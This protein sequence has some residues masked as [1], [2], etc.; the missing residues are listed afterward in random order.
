MLIMMAGLEG[1]GKSTLALQLAAALPG[2]VLN[3]DT[4]RAALFSPPLVEY[5]TAQ[6]DFCVDIM[7]QVAGYLLRKAPATYVILDGRPF[8][9]R[10]Q[11]DA[12]VEFAAK[13]PDTLKIIHCT[14][15]DE[16]IRQRLES[17]MSA[18]VHPAKNRTYEQYLSTKRRFEPIDR[19]RLLVDTDQPLPECLDLCLDY[20]QGANQA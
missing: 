3:K 14:A 6:D 12:V 7:L 2:V 13:L 17:D 18:A 9:R 5:S 11:V 15:S 8:S 10:Y 4:I 16:T 19:P 1:S 20:I